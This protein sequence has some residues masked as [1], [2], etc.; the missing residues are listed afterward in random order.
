MSANFPRSPRDRRNRV[1]LP[2]G[3]RFNGRWTRRQ[4]A[5]ASLLATLGMLLAAI[6]PGFSDAT[7]PAP[8]ATGQVTR[9]LALPELPVSRKRSQPGDSWQ[10][11]TIDDHRMPPKT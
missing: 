1:S 3:E 6:V 9:A 5:H 11:V 10:V 8:L 2:K 7:R 4:W